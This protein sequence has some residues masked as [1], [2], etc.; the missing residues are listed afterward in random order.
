MDR[1]SFL[2]RAASTAT[3]SLPLTAFMARA[4]LAQGRRGGAR[5]GHTAGDGP[6]FPTRDRATGLP[7]LLLTRGFTYVSFGWRGDPLEDGTLAPGAHDGMAAFPAGRG[8]V[9]LVRNH[10][11]GRGT[12]F[13]TVAYDPAAGGGTTTLEFDTQSGEL[14]TARASLSGT[15]RNC[16]G[17]PTPWGTWLTCEETNDYT[18]MPHGYVFEVAADGLGDPTPLRDMGRFS[19]EAVAVDP[20]TGYVYETED[21]GNSSGFY[22]FVPRAPG[23][24]G[25][26]GELFMMK[27]RAVPLANLGASYPVGTTIDVDRVPVPTPDNT[28]P[29]ALATF[30]WRQGRAQG[31]ATFARLEGCWSGRDLS[32]RRQ[33]RRAPGRTQRHLGGFPRG[34]VGRRLRQPRRAV[35]LREHLFSRSHGRHHGPVGIGCAVTCLRSGSR[36]QIEFQR[37]GCGGQMAPPRPASSRLAGD[38]ADGHRTT[39]SL[40]HAAIREKDSRARARRGLADRAR[41]PSMLLAE[42]S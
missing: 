21:A 13:S 32:L 42:R 37:R 22:R 23:Q 29:T 15:I 31:A 26:G 20:S 30:V 33:Q 2:K 6:L 40:A 27:A 7:L 19:H 36:D 39:V 1:R 38:I 9:R 16:A 3:A 12:P 34:R 41:G 18:T 4:D 10:E 11:V 14:I 8:R 35:A 24:L 17:G 5:R 25:P 28:V